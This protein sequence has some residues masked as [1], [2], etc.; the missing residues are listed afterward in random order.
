MSF[1]KSQ[2]LFAR[3]CRRSLFTLIE[4]LVVV[5]IIAILISMLAPALRQ[6]IA[7]AHLVGCTSNLKQVAYAVGAY[8]EDYY[9]LPVWQ[10]GWPMAN[11]DWGK[12]MRGLEK[13]LSSY[14]GSKMPGN[15]WWTAGHPIFACPASPVRWIPEYDP[16]NGGR[17]DHGGDVAN[18]FWRNT[19]EGLYFTYKESTANTATDPS[20]GGAM[21]IKPLQLAHY[22]RPSATPFQ[23]CSRRLSTAWDIGGSGWPNNTIGAASWHLQ[24]QFGPR[25]TYFLDGH[26]GILRDPTYTR[27][28]SLEMNLGSFSTY[29]F[30]VGTGSSQPFDFWLDEY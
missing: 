10:Q 6:A 5:A 17:Y 28:G 26:I 2:P 18:G 14:V 30:V 12:D 3:A 19:Y 24:E 20:I 21:S 13:C 11:E 15:P 1:P 4:L 25:P 7:S 9:L 8:E 29:E 27:H 23:F 22:S 16:G